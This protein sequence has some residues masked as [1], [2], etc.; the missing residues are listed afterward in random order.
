MNRVSR[1]VVF[2]NSFTKELYKVSR[3]KRIKRKPWAVMV[4]F[5]NN[6]ELKLIKV[7]DLKR[8]VIWKEVMNPGDSEMIAPV[9]SSKDTMAGAAGEV[10]GNLNE[11]GIEIVKSAQSATQRLVNAAQSIRS[12]FRSGGKMNG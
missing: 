5:K 9:K 10:K 3:I 8:S 4:N 1:G 6:R 7:T 11:A 12:M 2:K